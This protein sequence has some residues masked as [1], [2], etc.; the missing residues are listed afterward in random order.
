MSASPEDISGQVSV[1]EQ[2][3]PISPTL[4][5]AHLI[6]LYSRPPTPSSAPKSIKGDKTPVYSI[7]LLPTMTVKARISSTISP[8]LLMFQPL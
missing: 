5:H 7:L 2:L 6:Q 3:Q 4:G 8:L 1:R